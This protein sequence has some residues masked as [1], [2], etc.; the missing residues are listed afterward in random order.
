MSAFGRLCVQLSQKGN[1]NLVRIHGCDPL[2]NDATFGY[3]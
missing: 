1:M 2:R 3:R